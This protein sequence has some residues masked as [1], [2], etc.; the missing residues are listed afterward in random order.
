MYILCLWF[1]YSVRKGGFYY[2][3]PKVK[4]TPF[5][6]GDYCFIT[7]F[8]HFTSIYVCQAE[9]NEATENYKQSDHD[10]MKKTAYITGKIFIFIKFLKY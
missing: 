10:I 2:D 1:L 3:Q 4:Y 6:S 8:D 5:K 9:K 7:H